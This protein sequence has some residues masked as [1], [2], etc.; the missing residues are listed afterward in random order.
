M[1][2]AKCVR[3]LAPAVQWGGHVEWLHPIGGLKKIRAG[4]CQKC[5]FRGFV[6]MW[7]AAMGVER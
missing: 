6:G 4:W 5:R 1:R 3:C 7:R 2:T